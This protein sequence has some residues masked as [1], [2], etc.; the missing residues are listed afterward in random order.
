M[1]NATR[2]M[3]CF[4]HSKE[5]SA[6]CLLRFFG[7]LLVSDTCFCFVALVAIYLEA[8]FCLSCFFAGLSSAHLLSFSLAQ[9]LL[10]STRVA[11][12]WFARSLVL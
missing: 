8:S 9:L 11:N 5:P 3:R 4:S 12:I 2:N 1:L 10:I 6:N 7:V